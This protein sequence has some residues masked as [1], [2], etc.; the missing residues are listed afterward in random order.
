MRQDKEPTRLD[1]THR[2][3]TSW[4]EQSSKA[5]HD[6]PS[7]REVDRTKISQAPKR[8]V[9]TTAKVVRWAWGTIYLE[10]ANTRTA[11][12]KICIKYLAFS[13]VW[14]VLH[15]SPTKSTKDRN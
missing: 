8:R 14:N 12:T 4:S 10:T 13:T 5:P 3:M 6:P 1:E 7:M 15:P 11:L 2:A 9:Q